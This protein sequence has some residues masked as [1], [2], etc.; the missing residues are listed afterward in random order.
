MGADEM[1]RAAGFATGIALLVPITLSTMAVVLLVPILPQLQ[2]EFAD[3]P[4]AAYLVPMI[5]TV[6]ALCVA[7]FSPVAGIL[8]DYFGRRRLLLWSLLVY[9]VLG[10]MPLFLSS[11]WSIL[12]SRVGVGITEALIMTLSTTLIGDYFKGAR[13]DK[14]LAAQTAFASLSALLFFN[15]GG[16]LGTIGWRAPFW[17][18]A[19]ALVMLLG[20]A[21]FTW[22]PGKE[23]GTGENERH[24][25]NISWVAFPWSRMAGIILVTIFASILFYTVQIQ[26]SPGLVLLGLTSSAHIGFLTSVASIGVPLGTLIYSRVCLMPVQRLLLVEFSVLGAGFML[27][28]S[29]GT[30]PAFMIGCGLNQIGAGMLLPTLLV[31]AMSQLAFEVRARGTGIWQSA[32]ALGQW[33]SPIVITTISLRVDGLLPSF[34]WLA[35]GAFA[36]AALAL[37]S[38]FII[39]D[40]GAARAPVA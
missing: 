32:F 3:V 20:V 6:P 34:A 8:G 31:W 38:R 33:L 2:A 36:A 12:A 15:V 24:L 25:H 18:Y 1:K 14:W 13:R 40:S 16:I 39:K 27:M 37:L 30:V 11:I 7:I 22:E 35:Y 17:V 23:P 4:G 10:I 9:G 29:A 28:S 21:Y 5:L 19:S 26:S